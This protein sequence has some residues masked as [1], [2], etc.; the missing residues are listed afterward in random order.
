M[1]RSSYKGPYVPYTIWKLIK[2]INIHRS[3]KDNKSN[4][5]QSYSIRARSASILPTF[6]GLTIS[7]YNGKKYIPV[8]IVE[9]MVGYK[10]GQFAPTRTFKGHSGDKKT[11]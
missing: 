5:H 11:K 10:F 7:V 8:H 3:N 2:K 9:E 6:V 4:K 1:S